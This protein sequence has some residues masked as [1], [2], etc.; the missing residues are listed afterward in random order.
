M[1]FVNNWS[2]GITLAAGATSCALDLP[3]GEY[4]LVVSD[5]AGAAI[6]V[7]SADVLDGVANLTRAQEGT[8]D[9]EWPAGS[10]V[11]C[12]LTAA[13][14]L[15]L[16]AAIAE[17]QA[18][19]TALEPPPVMMLLE[20]LFTE[21]S[22]VYGDYPKIRSVEALSGGVVEATLDLEL[23]SQHEGIGAYVDYR[24][25]DSG[26]PS[27][28]IGT[29]DRLTVI[30]TGVVQDPSWG[31]LRVGLDDI[32]AYD[33]DCSVLNSYSPREEIGTGPFVRGA[34]IVYVD[35]PLI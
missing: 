21:E 11:G 28:R 29:T 24:A 19:V 2:R 1:N 34:G 26:A 20:V 17:L 30:D 10:K 23:F 14:L 25:N 16:F 8:A 5:A 35:I 32:S 18:R 7:V 6:E 12:S 15:G 22:W 33:G 4:R 9:A 31:A 27:V 13:T 3:D